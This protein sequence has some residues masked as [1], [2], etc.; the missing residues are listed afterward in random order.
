MFFLVVVT[1]T[2]TA[3]GIVFQSIELS[4]KREN[5]TTK[6]IID[7]AFWP[8]FGHT[9]DL[10]KI[11]DESNEFK[12]VNRSGGS[13]VSWHQFNHTVLGIYLIIILVLVNI[14]IAMFK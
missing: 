9:D 3:F 14:L 13:I 4:H 12:Y 11:I 5:I 7:S 1:I 2:F 10:G 8:I 6:G